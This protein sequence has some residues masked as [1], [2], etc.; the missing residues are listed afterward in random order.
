[1]KV[2]NLDKL[3]KSEGREVVIFGKT[4]IVEGMTVENFIETTNA[5]ERLRGE[6]SLVKQIEATI[7]MIVRSIPSVDR[8]DLLKLSLD[9]LQ[10]IVAFVRGDDVEG[11]E[12]A[13]PATEESSGE[14]EAKK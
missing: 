13:K 10:A 11:V 9:Q 8:A 1:M 12:S 5:A 2:L 4:Y 14:G 7:S 6:V 3:T